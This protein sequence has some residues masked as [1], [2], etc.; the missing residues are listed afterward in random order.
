MKKASRQKSF[1]IKEIQWERKSK[2]SAL[3]DRLKSLGYFLGTSFQLT[4]STK[5]W[6]TA[7]NLKIYAS[8]RCGQNMI[9]FSSLIKQ[10]AENC[11]LSPHKQFESPP[12]DKHSYLLPDNMAKIYYLYTQS[13]WIYFDHKS[14][15]TDIDRVSKFWYNQQSKLEGLLWPKV[16][17]IWLEVFVISLNAR[18][19]FLYLH[20]VY[21]N[22]ASSYGSKYIHFLNT[23]EAIF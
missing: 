1:V 10:A 20:F 22:K 18:A 2:L 11:I 17:N 8:K 3:M 16:I 7:L 21:I 19:L 13:L 12:F 15:Q 5:N 6:Q 23:S 4:S 9:L 14:R